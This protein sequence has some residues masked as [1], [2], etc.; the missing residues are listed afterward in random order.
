MGGRAERGPASVP[1]DGGLAEPAAYEP[2]GRCWGD[3]GEV[4]TE[5]ADATVDPGP[6]ADRARAERAG[7]GAAALPAGAVAATAA[8]ADGDGDAPPELAAEPVPVAKICTATCL[9]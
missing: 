1:G 8:D 9:H 3:P 6:G 5:N 7:L 4:I 2:G